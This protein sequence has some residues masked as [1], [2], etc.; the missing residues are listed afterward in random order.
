MIRYLETFYRHPRLF[1]APVILALVSSVVFAFLQPVTYQAQARIW[2]DLKGGLASNNTADSGFN[3]YV[4]PAERQAQVLNELI[5]TRAFA[6]KV[7]HRGALAAY[8]TTPEGYAQA[9][10]PLAGAKSSI[11]AMFDGSTPKVAADQIDDLS[12][13]L[14]TRDT[15]AF[16]V[17]P[18]MVLITVSLPSAAA[19]EST[20]TA[21]V[22]QYSDEV[23]GDQRMQAQ[24]AVTFWGQQA[25]VAKASVKTSD[26]VIS[27]YLA[28]HPQLAQP[29]AAPDATLN[30]LRHTYDQNQQHYA[31]ILDKLDQAK[32]DVA[33]ST[34]EASGFRVIDRPRSVSPAA[35]L[36]RNLTLAMGGLVTGLLISASGI[37]AMT[38]LDPTLRRREELKSILGLRVIAAIPLLDVAQR[39]RYR[40]EARP[41]GRAAGTGGRPARAERTA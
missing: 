18:Q 32:L 19:A 30:V 1:I 38:L 34:P 17:G 20:L 41:I 16:A 28:Q 10:G 27:Q 23:L 11:K 37:V 22:D 15:T 14:I 29:N 36:K 7:A 8:V 21:L 9:S 24:T 6:A 25:D 31:S 35:G 2:Y 39:D 4:T 40:R 33:A 5:N 12:Y 26:D 13:T 3:Q